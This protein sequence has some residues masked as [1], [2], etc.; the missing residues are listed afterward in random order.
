MLNAYPFFFFFV[1]FIISVSYS[2]F[3]GDVV[4]FVNQTMQAQSAQPDCSYPEEVADGRRLT[5][6]W[7]KGQEPQEVAMSFAQTH[8]I[9]AAE[10]PD[11]VAFIQQVSG[12]PSSVSAQCLGVNYNVFV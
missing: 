4:A 5:I 8:G 10:L 7:N 9:G 11:I 2:A 6:S 12:S 3:Q 1:K